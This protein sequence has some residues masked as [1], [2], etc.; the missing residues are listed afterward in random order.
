[1]TMEHK[2]LNNISLKFLPESRPHLGDS[3]GFPPTIGRRGSSDLRQS[4][5][6]GLPRRRYTPPQLCS[7]TLPCSDCLRSAVPSCYHL[8]FIQRLLLFL[9][10]IGDEYAKGGILIVL[11]GVA[12]TQPSSSIHASLLLRLN[13][14]GSFSSAPIRLRSAITSFY[15]LRLLIPMPWIYSAGK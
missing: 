10:Q 11:F 14:T 4:G 1:M 3:V 15:N 7:F 8:R 13:L 6:S 12:A 9:V 5:C 2:I